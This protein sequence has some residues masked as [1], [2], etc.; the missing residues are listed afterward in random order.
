VAYHVTQRGTGGQPVFYSDGDR[1]TYL[2]LSTAILP[3]ANL[4]VL[5]FCL[6]TNHVHWIVVPSL[7][8]ALAVF[9]RRLHGRY[10][11]YLNARLQRSGH[12]WQNRYFGCALGRTHLPRALAYVDQ[13]PVRAGLVLHANE[14][15]WSS[16]APHNG[17]AASPVPLANDPAWTTFWQPDLPS[18]VPMDAK[19]LSRCT[20]SGRPF[21]DEALVAEFEQ[22]FERKWRN[23]G[24]LAKSRR[25]ERESVGAL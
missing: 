15:R 14:F 17:L 2:R 23:L 18:I 6:M 12:L 5:G 13:N 25:G 24:P 7:P 16:A 4:E 10:S 20:Y 22:R 3:E 8:D 19:V 21:G 11:Q 9:F 1:W